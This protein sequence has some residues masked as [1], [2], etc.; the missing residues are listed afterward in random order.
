MHTLSTKDVLSCEKHTIP[1]TRNIKTSR[2]FFED[3]VYNC[4]NQIRVNHYS[5]SKKGHEM[6]FQWNIMQNSGYEMQID[7]YKSIK[8]KFF[9]VIFRSN[10]SFLFE[11]SCSVIIIL[12]RIIIRSINFF[13]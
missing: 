9:Q 10:P 6:Q 13:L 4:I 8:S 11:I 1:E 2:S 7:M 5:F 12:S 3:K